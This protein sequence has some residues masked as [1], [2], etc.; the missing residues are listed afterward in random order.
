[1]KTPSV[2]SKIKKLHPSV[3]EQLQRELSKIEKAEKIARL[4][5]NM[6]STAG[7]DYDDIGLY[8]RRTP[9]PKVY[10]VENK[11]GCIGMDTRTFNNLQKARAYAIQIN[12]TIYRRDNSC[13]RGYTPRPQRIPLPN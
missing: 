8:R 7:L 4:L 3:R 9:K 10:R 1:M 12:G 13:P 2:R 11:L 6:L 5:K